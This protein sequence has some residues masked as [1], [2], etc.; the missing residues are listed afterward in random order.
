MPA[1]PRDVRAVQTHGGILQ[2]YRPATSRVGASRRHVLAHALPCAR[3][4]VSPPA[5]GASSTRTRWLSS[6]PPQAAQEDHLERQVGIDLRRNAA[7]GI[8][9]NEA[10]VTL[11]VSATTPASFSGGSSADGHV[12]FQVRGEGCVGPSADCIVLTV[13]TPAN[14]SSR[15]RHAQAAEAN[16]AAECCP[17][18]TVLSRTRPAQAVSRACR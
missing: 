6:R 17:A 3:H 14:A 8:S 9:T 2:E 16:A 1:L 12:V 13:I 7:E 11:T 4:S 15:M 5:R 10:L 18:V